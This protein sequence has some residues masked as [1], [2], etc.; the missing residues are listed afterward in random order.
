MRTYQTYGE[1]IGGLFVKSIDGSDRVYKAM[2]SRGYAGRSVV[3][4]AQKIK[5]L[6]VV[7]SMAMLISVAALYFI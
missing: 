7:K 5:A 1:I 3:A 2:I 6:D 4:E